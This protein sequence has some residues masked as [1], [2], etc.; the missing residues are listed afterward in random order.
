MVGLSGGSTL[1]RAHPVPLPASAGDSYSSLYVWPRLL[2]DPVLPLWESA[3]LAE[4]WVV[5]A[6]AGLH[7]SMPVGH[8]KYP[9]SG[10]EVVE[11]VVGVVHPQVLLCHLSPY[12]LSLTGC[13]M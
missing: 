10:S 2:R 8:P 5:V 4:P 1:P 13:S 3:S 6:S 12:N 7:Q 11:V 9:N